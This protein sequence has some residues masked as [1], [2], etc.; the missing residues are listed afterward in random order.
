M[1]LGEE[2]RLDVSRYGVGTRDMICILHKQPPW[3]WCRWFTDHTG[4]AVFYLMSGLY[5]IFPIRTIR[6]LRVL[7]E[8]LKSL[9]MVGIEDTFVNEF[10]LDSSS[11]RATL[12]AYFCPVGPSYLNIFLPS[13]LP[14]SLPP[15][16]LPICLHAFV[17]ITGVVFVSHETV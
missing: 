17:E 1:G 15:S 7:C 8:E 4:E 2:F 3:F 6:F 14:P 13:F 10:L 9:S 12:A 5:F 11:P 16:L